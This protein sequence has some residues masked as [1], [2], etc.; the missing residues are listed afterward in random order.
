MILLGIYTGSRLTVLLTVQWER[1]D[2]AGYI[3]LNEE[4]MYRK[5]EGERET[6]KRKPPVKLGR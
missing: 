6:K 5:A 1:N 4:I 3:D 2:R